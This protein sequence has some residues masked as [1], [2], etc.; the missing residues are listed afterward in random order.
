MDIHYKQCNKVTD[1]TPAPED[2]DNKFTTKTEFNNLSIGGTNLWVLSDL[3]TGHETSGNITANDNP[4][5]KIRKTLIDVS[6]TNYITYQI[7]N[8]DGIVNDGNTNRIAWYDSNQTYISSASIP[9]LNGSYQTAKYKRPSNAKYVRLSA[10]VGDT[11]I[12]E[13]IKVKYEK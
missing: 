12:N 7:W 11:S 4:V 5:H 3:T 13:N 9:K 6:D 1:W 2:V 8:P 10:I